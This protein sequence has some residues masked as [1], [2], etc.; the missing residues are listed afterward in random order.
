MKTFV[1]MLAAILLCLQG[2]SEPKPLAAGGARPSVVLVVLD[3]VGAYDVEHIDTPNL[4]ALAAI[5]MEFRRAYAMPTC[6]SARSSL[7]FGTYGRYSGNTCEPPGPE[8]PDS[9]RFSLP[10]CFESRGYSTLFTGKWHLGTNRLGRPWEETPR[11]HGF[12]QVLAGM[13]QNLADPCDH[14]GTMGYDRW[15]RFDRG[16]SFIETG[17]NTTV[18]RGYSDRHL[19]D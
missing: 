7:F 10:K 12:D 6:A 5:G 16:P 17:Y 19:R 15:V 13:G 14:P 1:L 18:L 8:T 4:H 3:D 9:T 2:F 11:L